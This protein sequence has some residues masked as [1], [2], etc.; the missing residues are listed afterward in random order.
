MRPTGARRARW[1]SAATVALALSLAGPLARAQGGAPGALPAG[2]APIRKVDPGGVR[3]WPAGREPFVD[4]GPRRGLGWPEGRE[5]F[6]TPLAPPA[7]PPPPTPPASP[8]P[9]ASPLLPALPQGRAPLGPGAPAEWPEGREPFGEPLPESW[10]TGRE[11]VAAFGAPNAGG[12]PEGREPLTFIDPEGV[13]GWPE[14]REP[15]RRAA[16]AEGAPAAAAGPTPRRDPA[17]AQGLLADVERVVASEEAGEW[18]DDASRYRSAYPVLLPSVCRAT[19][20]ARSEALALALAAWRRQGD[21]RAIFSSNGRIMSPRVARALTLE[22][23]YRALATAVA[24]AEADCPFWVVPEEG[25]P[26]RQT[27]RGRAT[28]N[29]E[30]GGLFQLRYGGGRFT[31]GGGG[32]LRV[33]PGYRVADNLT[34]LAGLELA[35]GAL[36]ETRRGASQVVLHYFPALP[37]VARVHDVAW[38]YD[39]ELAPV[40][41]F[42]AN[43]GDLSYG[44]RVGFGL[45]VSALRTRWFIPWAGAAVAYEHYFEGGGRPPTE[46][47]RG[48]LRIGVQWAL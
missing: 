30:T 45:G 43:D 40:A 27:T 22:R 32:N 25:Y 8:A 37:L 7:S 38:H 6:V 29:A 34:L 14:G 9:P 24:G 20:A 10:P 26:G 23:H 12:W 1:R 44:A 18:F 16:P 36:L 31:Y 15:P 39:F 35:G 19:P 21:A 11:S 33:L 17:G 4:A 28:I 13:G 46:L 41:L 48:G 2:R 42:Q 3:G 5:P 47:V